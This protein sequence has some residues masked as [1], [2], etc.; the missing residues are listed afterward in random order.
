MLRKQ[1][2]M[3]I[4]DGDHVVRAAV[5]IAYDLD[6]GWR[7]RIIAVHDG[8]ERVHKTAWVDREWDVLVAAE[9]WMRSLLDAGA[10]E[11]ESKRAA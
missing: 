11:P 9:A 10:R 5:T 3:L 2:S 6:L 4:Q 7:A 1:L 8:E